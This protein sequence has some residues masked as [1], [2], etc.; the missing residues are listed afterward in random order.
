MTLGGMSRRLVGSRTTVIWWVL[1]LPSAA[2][3]LFLLSLIIGGTPMQ[4]GDYFYMLSSVFN[5]AGQ[6]RPS[7]LL[8]HANEHLVAIPKLVY[9]ANVSLFDGSNISL[10]V[11]VWA[12]SLAVALLLGVGLWPLLADRSATGVLIIWSISVV[13]FPLAALHNFIYAMSGTAW[14]LANLFAILALLLLVKGRPLAAGATGSLATFSY[15]TGLAVWPALVACLVLQRRRPT[16]RE[17][18]MLAMGVGAVVIQRVTADPVYGHPNPTWSP[19][20]L[21][22]SLAIAVGSF[23]TRNT[24]LAVVLGATL[25]VLLVQAAGL[26][27][28]R[29]L[30]G[31]EVF[32]AG[33][34]S[35]A[36][37]AL[38]LISVARSS[39]G[40][41]TLSVSRYMTLSGLACI[42]MALLALA[43]WSGGRAWRTGTAIGVALALMA[44]VPLIESF[45]QVIVDQEVAAVAARLGVA[46][47]G[48]LRGYEPGSGALLQTLGSYPFSTGFDTDCGLLGQ[49]VEGRLTSDVSV[50]DGTI[51][52]LA[53]APNE[54]AVNV[55]GWVYS[56]S[57][58]ECVIFIDAEG[59]VIGAATQGL[60][61][62]D[63][64][65]VHGYPRTDVGFAGV[66]LRTKGSQIRAVAVVGNAD[67]LYRLDGVQGS[68][69]P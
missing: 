26:V 12:L 1:V 41:E 36:V 63:V 25:L 17:A 23:L 45:R 66:A 47:D 38:L 28:R 21:S 22:H 27:L 57:P 37:V 49:N 35:Y 9:A 60:E 14:I 5:P 6:F 11:F 39:F 61:R 42:G 40:D 15:G 69:V 3:P 2:V 16:W 43:A 19:L 64:R 59:T 56:D 10:G 50:V 33:I 62:L 8:V 31:S 48:Y 68:E 32:A 67:T 55:S 51:D 18:L 7:G 29:A 65:A 53:V 58:V 44:G 13:A 52:D 54:K 24:E 20:T 30:T 46:G 34:T 4:F